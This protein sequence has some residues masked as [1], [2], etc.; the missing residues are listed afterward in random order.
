MKKTVLI[1]Y[2][3]LLTSFF[4]FAQEKKDTVAKKECK[5][6]IG[7]F[8]APNYS[9]VKGI[10]TNNSDIGNGLYRWSFELLI[11]YRINA[12][13]QLITGTAFNQFGYCIKQIGPIYPNN[14]IPYE[15]YYIYYEFPAIP[16]QFHYNYYL[17]PRCLLYADLGFDLSYYLGEKWTTYYSNTPSWANPNSWS[18]G[19]LYRGAY[20]P[21]IIMPFAIAGIGMENKIYKH[22]YSSFS[23]GYEYSILPLT[24]SYQIASTYQFAY[25]YY[26]IYSYFFKI[27]VNCKL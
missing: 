15:K 10:Q 8:T 18:H 25:L 7:I 9:Y 12:H 13:F 14:P 16:L 4:S 21:P 17:K 5:W 22:L 27:G 6:S 19:S 2:L 23:L 11:N 20:K 26:H 3:L 1:F 24:Y